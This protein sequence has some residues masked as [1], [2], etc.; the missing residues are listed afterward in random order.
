MTRL[1][2]CLALLAGCNTPSP[3]E[4]CPRE[5]LGNGAVRAEYSSLL[6]CVCTWDRADGGSR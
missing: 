5:C 1:L 4:A 3:Y 6:G 2:L